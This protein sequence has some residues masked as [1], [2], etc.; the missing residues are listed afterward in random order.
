M[1]EIVGGFG[2]AIHTDDVDFGIEVH[3][4]VIHIKMSNLIF[5]G[6]SVASVAG[7]KGRGYLSY[8]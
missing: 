6:A 7:K 2:M 4:C 8:S 5:E 3:V 1:L